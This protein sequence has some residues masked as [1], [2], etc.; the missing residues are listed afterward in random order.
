LRLK[1]TKETNF[2]TNYK[3]NLIIIPIKR[4][5]LKLM[6]RLIKLFVVKVKLNRD[7]INPY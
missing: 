2:I 6:N 4:T 3:Y 1:I 5:K 7:Q